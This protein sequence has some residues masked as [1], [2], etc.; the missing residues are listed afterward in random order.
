MAVVVLVAV[1]LWPQKQ[2]DP[3]AGM[4]VGCLMIV[5]VGVVLVAGLYA[6][7]VWQ[8][9]VWLRNGIAWGVISAAGYLTVMLV[10]SAIVRAAKRR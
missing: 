8:N 1:M 2:H 3:Q 10:A 4:A 5:L 9:I 7:G 6:L